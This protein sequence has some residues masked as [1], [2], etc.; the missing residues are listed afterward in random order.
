ML[1]NGMRM[2]RG[3]LSAS[4]GLI[5]EIFQS[6]YHLFIQEVLPKSWGRKA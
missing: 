1:G 4:G 6:K 3:V 2:T 5:M